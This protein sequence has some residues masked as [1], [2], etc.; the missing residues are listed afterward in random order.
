MDGKDDIRKEA[1]Q[2]P[3]TERQQ[4]RDLPA[5]RREAENDTTDGPTRYRDW[6][7]I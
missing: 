5:A 4:P 1:P 2:R 3:D 7:S 6:A